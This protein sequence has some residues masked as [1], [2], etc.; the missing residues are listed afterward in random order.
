MI[1]AY[2]TP[3]QILWQ[4]DTAIAVDK[5]A[6][7]LVHN[8]KWA[9][10]KEISLRQLAARQL[11]RQVY[12]IHRLDRPTS[13]ILL[14]ALDG[15]SA[16][17]WHDQLAHPD[18]VKTYVVLARG[19]LAGPMTVDHPLKKGKTRRPALTH[20]RPLCYCPEER[21]TLAL[22]R[23]RTGR[24]HQIRRHLARTAHQII[25]DTTYGKGRINNHFR[26]A[27][28]L[29]RLFLHA[30]RLDITHPATGQRL[31]LH[32][33]LPPELLALLAHLCPDVFITAESLAPTQQT[34]PFH[35]IFPER[36]P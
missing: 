19:R 35:L 8:S 30:I 29:H 7:L 2:T 23:P 6:G 20:F 22:A 12:P 16:R 31:H 13:G 18:A 32:A 26:E 33:P 24:Q 28:G 27:Y 25:G 36:T 9:G 14:Y 5:P 1:S 10:P 4:D 34:P 17:L 3:I 21:V 11:G 15:D